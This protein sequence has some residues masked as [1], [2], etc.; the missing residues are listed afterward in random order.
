MTLWQMMIIAA[1]A[2]TID[3]SGNKRIANITIG[4]YDHAVLYHLHV[5]EYRDL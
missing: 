3:Q 1:F 4:I 2:I 5:V